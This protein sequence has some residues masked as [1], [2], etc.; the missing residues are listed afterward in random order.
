M[1]FKWRFAGGPMLARILWYLDP[2]S[3]QQLKKP[4]TWAPLAKLS[5]SAHEKITFL[6]RRNDVHVG[7]V[8]LRSHWWADPGIIVREWG[9][10]TWD[11][12]TKK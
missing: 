10:G 8:R 4:Q 9:S 6:R 1:P 3:S 7:T 5:G 2:L 11:I 12:L